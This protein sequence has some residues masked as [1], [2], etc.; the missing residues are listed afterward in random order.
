MMMMMGCWGRR[1]RGEGRLVG[2]FLFW[3]LI[4]EEEGKGIVIFRVRYSK[5]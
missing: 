4:E 5:K 3:F 2:F 1:R